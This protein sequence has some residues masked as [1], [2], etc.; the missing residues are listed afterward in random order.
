MKEKDCKK[1]AKNQKCCKSDNC[2]KGDGVKMYSAAD[3][4]G[5]Y[6]GV[7]K[8]KSNRPVQDADDL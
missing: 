1:S 2:R 5:S 7:A 8:E 6:T 3:P 4:N